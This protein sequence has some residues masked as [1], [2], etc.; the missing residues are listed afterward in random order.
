MQ[1][2]NYAH[3]TSDFEVL[4][5]FFTKYCIF[6]LNYIYALY[7]FSIYWCFDLQ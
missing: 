1:V 7:Y 6:V 2:K 5:F 3:F 4:K